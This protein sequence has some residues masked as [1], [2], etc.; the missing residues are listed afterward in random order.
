M[1]TRGPGLI[2]CMPG[3]APCCAE[4]MGRRKEGCSLRVLGQAEP[5]PPDLDL[6]SKGICSLEL[7]PQPQ[8]SVSTLLRFLPPKPPSPSPS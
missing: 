6:G 3:W 5:R 4:L 7:L 1:G 2:V 8:L